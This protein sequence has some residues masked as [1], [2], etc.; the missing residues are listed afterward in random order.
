MA[1]WL[2]ALASEPSTPK[3]RDSLLH[4]PSGRRS[5]PDELRRE[6][7]SGWALQVEQLARATDPVMDADLLAAETALGTAA[8]VVV[9]E[10]PDDRAFDLASRLMQ[11]FSGVRNSFC[12]SAE[13]ALAEN[14]SAP[15][16]LRDMLLRRV[17]DF[18]AAPRRTTYLQNGANACA[19]VG[20]YWTQARVRDAWCNSPWSPN[21]L[22]R[23][24]AAYYL[25]MRLDPDKWLHVVERFPA[26]E[27]VAHIIQDC[28]PERDLG[29]LLQ[30][31][32]TAAA[33]FASDGTWRREHKAIFHL[34]QAAERLLAS[35]AGPT[36][37]GGNPVTF[38]KALNQVVEAF[39]GRPDAS[40]LGHAWLEELAWKD[41]ATGQ[42]RAPRT[43]TAAVPDALA[44]VFAAVGRATPLR[45]DPLNWIE[46]QDDTWRGDRLI[47]VLATVRERAAPDEVGALLIEAALRDVGG[48]ER[49]LS[50][51]ATL[52]GAVVG[53]AVA[54]LPNPAAWMQS[55]WE[56]TFPLRDR[57]RHRS[58]RDSGIVRDVNLLCI[59]WGV[60]GLE[61]LDPS[62]RIA[63]DLWI[64]LAEIIREARLTVGDW[65]VAGHAAE[66][67]RCLA[68]M[69]PP[70][71]HQRPT[72]GA[73]GSLSE[74]L[75]PFAS[76]DREYLS[77]IVALDGLG[78]SLDEISS[79]SGGR[80]ALRAMVQTALTDL[81]ALDERRP[82]SSSGTGT[83]ERLLS[84]LV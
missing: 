19:L 47:A 67:Q 24:E 60:A 77:I 83:L 78:V 37:A 51:G 31:I 15:T 29:R 34:L 16:R 21:M 58:V 81:R 69:W 44:R 39:A 53:D 40:P 28:R 17:D 63:H 49:M 45:A 1:A 55:L 8:G 14:A 9:G 3:D 26:P 80:Y 32:E 20:A 82:T 57:A 66:A 79:A 72:P 22:L 64:E 38:E 62:V 48:T 13:R 36:E 41:Y 42:W 30:L 35:L 10:E 2:R 25:L 70:I 46:G 33:P 23:H 59:A 7:L 5:L 12:S 56:R 61:R 6:G 18:T 73:P 52:A 68:L 43:G 4:A 75:G 74:F 54:R 84:R 50:G 65:D 27:P 76:P 71:F 11:R